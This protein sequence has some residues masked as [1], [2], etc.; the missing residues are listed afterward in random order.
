M[1][2][3]EKELIKEA[4][5]EARQDE[6]GASDEDF[7]DESDSDDSADC[8]DDEYEKLLTS[9]KQITEEKDAK[10]VKESVAKRNGPTGQLGDS[11]DSDYDYNGGDLALYNS[12]FDN[13]NEFIACRDAM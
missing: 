4:K 8:N 13:L 1:N 3:K 7:E 12:A 9:L 5:G 11:S 6:D 2:F 10:R